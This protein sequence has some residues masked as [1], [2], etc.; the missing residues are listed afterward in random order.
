MQ[1]VIVCTSRHPPRLLGA[2]VNLAQAKGPHLFRPYICPMT[3]NGT[4][5]CVSAMARFEILLVMKLSPEVYVGRKAR[6]G[7]VDNRAH[8][9]FGL[10][11]RYVDPYW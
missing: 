5:F 6:N 8:D 3:R 7:G 9:C 1:C 11:R 2:V 10:L 4:V